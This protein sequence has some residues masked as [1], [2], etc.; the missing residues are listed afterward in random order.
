MNPATES[1]TCRAS[2]CRAA[3]RGD[4]NATAAISPRAPRTM[5]PAEPVS[6][7]RVVKAESRLGHRCSTAGERTKTASTHEMLSHDG[8]ARL[9]I[10]RP[11]LCDLCEALFSTE[12]E[13]IAHANAVHFRR[14]PGYVPFMYTCEVCGQFPSEHG[15]RDVAFFTHQSAQRHQSCLVF[16]KNIGSEEGEEAG[17]SVG[18]DPILDDAAAASTD[19]RVHE[20]MDDDMELWRTVFLMYRPAGN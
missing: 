4:G 2:G 20:T 14:G 8:A 11:I 3:R 13:L 12:G 15:R 5:T 10:V 18:G 16:W 1:K 6:G 9:E 17:A 19:G 7:G